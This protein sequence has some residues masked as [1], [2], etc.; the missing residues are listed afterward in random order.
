M[1]TAFVV[2]VMLLVGCSGCG[3][4]DPCEAATFCW[5]EVGVYVESAQPWLHAPD[6][7][8]RIRRALDISAA[9]WGAERLAGLRIHFMDVDACDGAGG[10]CT[11]YYDPAGWVPLDADYTYRQI[12]FDVS[13]GI[14]AGHCVESTPL[15][16]EIGHAVLWDP[17]HTDP[18]WDGQ[19]ALY[20]D[21]LA[22]PSLYPDC[23]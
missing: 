9:Y 4:F 5:D 8:V 2:A 14:G 1:K 15:A 13:Q 21:Q 3:R 7:E 20:V 6:T 17:G 12:E 16:H 10:G 18:R 19:V 11:T 23:Y 22:P